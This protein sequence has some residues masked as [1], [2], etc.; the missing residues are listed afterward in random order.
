MGTHIKKITIDKI[1][2]NIIIQTNRDSRR[3]AATSHNQA[4]PGSGG[5]I[6]FRRGFDNIRCLPLTQQNW[7]IES[8]M[9][10]R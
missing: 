3:P 10:N 8:R 5:W 2:I 9:A 6:T 1:D 4:R 7:L